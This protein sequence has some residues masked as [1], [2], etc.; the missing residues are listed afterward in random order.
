MLLPWTLIRNR[1][2]WNRLAFALVLGLLVACTLS[3][4][5]DQ[6]L[7]Y[8]AAMVLTCPPGLLVRFALGHTRDPHW[9]SIVGPVELSR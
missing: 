1:A 6:A 3:A 4:I 9:P 7:H 2:L 8:P 5:R